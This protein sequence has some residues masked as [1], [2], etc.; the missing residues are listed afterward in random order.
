[1]N[2]IIPVVLTVTITAILMATVLVPVIDDQLWD[3]KDY[4]NVEQS[5]FYMV[6]SV[7]AGDKVSNITYTASTDVLTVDGTTY[8]VP[9]GYTIACFGLGML[10]TGNDDFTLTV[11]YGLR[12]LTYTGSG[13][14]P[15]TYG[16]PDNMSWVISGEPSKYVMTSSEYTGI[17]ASKECPIVFEGITGISNVVH[18]FKITTDGETAEFNN[19]VPATSTVSNEVV[20]S[21]KVSG[22][23]DVYKLS[24]VQFD[25]TTGDGVV[26]HCIYSYGIAYAHVTGHND[27]PGTSIVAIIPAILIVGLVA[28]VARAFVAKNN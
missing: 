27:T 20:Y 6:A 21:S 24:S 1:M 28:M 17:Y 7:D 22:T 4:S 25:C 11:N 18:T 2:K 5:A 8:T 14:T 16:L 15:A 19:V 12:S 23:N 13:G 26:Q 3:E 9:A 10:R